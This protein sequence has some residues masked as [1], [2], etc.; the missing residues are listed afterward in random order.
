ML[1]WLFAAVAGSALAVL[2]YRF[3]GATGATVPRALRALAVT[4]VLALL[5]DAPGGPARRARPYA[6]P[7]GRRQAGLVRWTPTLWKRAVRS[8]DSVGSDTL[9]L[10]GD[11]LRAGTAPAEPGDRGTRV[12]PLVE[13]ALGAGRAAVF[14]TDG[15]VD[16]P[17]RLADL[18]SGS[19]IVTLEGA[20]RLDAAVVSVDGPAAAVVGDTVEFTAV[21][22]SGGAGSHMGKIALVQGGATLVAAAV[23]SLAPYTERAVRLRTQVGGARRGRDC[24][25]SSSSATDGDALP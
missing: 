2:Q 20:S 22:A 23:D 4:I 6:A 25:V 1:I 17:E 12:A 7:S 8:A 3:G 21:I 10:V 14:V 18:P 24:S 15:R 5:L 11:S 19:R 16:D 13:R 9:L